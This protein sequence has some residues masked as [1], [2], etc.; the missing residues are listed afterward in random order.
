MW[1]RSHIRDK[2]RDRGI[3]PVATGF[4]VIGGVPSDYRVSRPLA[5]RML[6]VLLVAVGAAVVL[7]TLAVAVLALPVTVLAAGVLVAVVVVLVAA[8]LVR[9]TTVVRL[10]QTGY[11]VR[12]VRGAG[13]TEAR[14]TDV[15]DVVTATVTGERCVVLR[16]R[17]GGTTTVP[18]RLLAAD[19]DEFVRDL[20]AHLDRG[21]GYRRIG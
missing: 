12:A 18:V 19:P 21:H 2:S 7:L 10:D 1:P 14:W 4:G 9:R 5:V 13:V 20:R 3:W 15:E 11:R 16:L 8:L 6:G 17:D